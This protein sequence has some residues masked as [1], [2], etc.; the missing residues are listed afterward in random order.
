MKILVALSTKVDIPGQHIDW[1]AAAHHGCTC[2]VANDILH[3]QTQDGM[4]QF[5]LKR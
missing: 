4:G 5:G 1:R 2:S 3:D